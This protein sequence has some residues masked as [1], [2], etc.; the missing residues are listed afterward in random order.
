MSDTI[1]PAVKDQIRTRDR[2]VGSSPGILLLSNPNQSQVSSDDEDNDHELNVSEKINHDENPKLRD[3][4]LVPRIKSLF[5][6]IPRAFRKREKV[7]GTDQ[8]SFSHSEIDT[9]QLKR[10][11][12]NYRWATVQPGV[13]PLTA[14][15]CD[16]PI[17]KPIRDAM[18]QYIQE[19]Y[20]NYG[21]S[22]GLPGLR[23]AI[24]KERDTTSNCVFIANSAASAMFLVAE[25][26]LSSGDEVLLMDPVDFLFQRA[27]EHAGGVVVR[28]SLKPPT[29]SNEHW[30]FSVNDII[31]LIT[32]KT[33][34]I[35]ICNPH[36]PVGN[37][38]TIREISDLCDI[39]SG[40]NL[41]L[42][43]DEVWADISYVP[44]TPSASIANR[45]GVK[46]FTVIGFSK[47]YGLA[48]L[49]IGAV[50]SPTG[51]DTDVLS[52]IS[53]AEDTAYGVSVLSQVAA[54]AAL[55]KGSLWLST[56][57]QHVHTQCQY[58]VQRMNKIPHV[59]CTMPEGTFVC[60]ANVSFYLNKTGLDEVALA[61]YLIKNFN[62]AVVPGAPTFF[63]PSAA[64]YI[65][66]SVATSKKILKEGLDRLS[67]GLISLL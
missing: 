54:Q 5:F 47:G 66:I 4:A 59:F 43:S 22:K 36:N 25:Y 41:I 30:T 26:C 61:S 38:W 24:A 14:A 12:Y 11:A 40:H 13:I 3:W 58:C 55:E 42:W 52:R 53:L 15:D 23:D 65:R 56:F 35:A 60:F 19:G 21:P 39:A 9:T 62:V 17:A 16:F 33:K 32:V 20:M 8:Y 63:G 2:L 46:T 7:N 51:S 44:F 64:G 6:S 48:G 37:V 29:L 28:Y 31:P 45:F 10:K 49:R 18:T 1:I 50:I 67:E 27:I 57:R 34:M